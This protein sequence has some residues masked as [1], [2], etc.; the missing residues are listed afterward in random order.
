MFYENENEKDI[1]DNSSEIQISEDGVVSWGDV[2]DDTTDDLIS[3]VDDDSAQDDIAVSSEDEIQIASQD[4]EPDEEELR[5]ILSEGDNSN[6]T[7]EEEP[8]PINSEENNAEDNIE[9]NIE[10]SEEFDFDS[11]DFGDIPQGSQ[12]VPEED[13]TPRNAPAK[14]KSGGIMPVLIALL[15]AI[16]VVGGGYYIY[17]FMMNNSASNGDLT[18]N[19]Q[20][21]DLTAEE[22]T[23]RANEQ[24]DIP[25]V[26]EDTENTVQAEEVPQEEKK[27]VVDIKVGGRSNPFLPN[28]KYMA[29]SVPET[30]INFENPSIPKPPSEYGVKDNE[31]VKMLSISVS[32]I[33]YDD[34]K[35]S[36]IITYD[37]NDYFVQRG[38]KLN[39]YR[40][41]DIGKNFVLISYGSNTYKA[42]VGEEFK[43][44]DNFYG[45]AKYLPTGRQYQIVDKNGGADSM[46]KGKIKDG[47]VEINVE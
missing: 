42:N 29:V 43:I 32:G 8:E 21:N 10:D 11:S 9:D 12:D 17:S 30:Y 22:I 3:V 40:V 34:V 33:M 27:E 46:G 31:A 47:S 26:N 18:A 2:L 41:I 20:V 13:I 23:R 7:S 35:P 44:T 16:I 38:D 39:E 37:D 6:I 19:N 14:E 15:V 24:Q 1:I 5:R 28:S 4:E 25:V 36:A 45:N